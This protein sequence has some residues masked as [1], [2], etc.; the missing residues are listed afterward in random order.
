VC[1]HYAAA[2]FAHFFVACVHR[3]HKYMSPPFPGQYIKRL[4]SFGAPLSP[5]PAPACGYNQA[6]ASIK[7]DT[8]KNNTTPQ[9]KAKN[10]T[11]LPSERKIKEGLWLGH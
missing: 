7:R 3:N 11:Y 8:G 5:Q 1:I 10:K 4:R 6:W 2:Q 9:S